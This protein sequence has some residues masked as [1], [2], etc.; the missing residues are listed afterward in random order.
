MRFRRVKPTSKGHAQVD[1]C[2]PPHCGCAVPPDPEQTKKRQSLK[3]PAGATRV[4]VS[5]VVIRADGSRDVIDDAAVRYR[6][7]IK[8]AWWQL[9]MQPRVERRILAANRRAEALRSE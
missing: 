3:L 2:N 6:N 8:N 5:H 7:P 4:S 1:E 9:I